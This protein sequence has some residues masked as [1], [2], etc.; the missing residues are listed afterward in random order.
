VFPVEKMQNLCYSFISF[1]SQLDIAANFIFPYT[2]ITAQ[3]YI[4]CL[5]PSTVK[6]MMDHCFRSQDA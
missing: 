6:E 3:Q 4:S 1:S 2:V 5:S